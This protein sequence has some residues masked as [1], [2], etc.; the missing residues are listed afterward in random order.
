MVLWSALVGCYSGFDTEGGQLHLDPS[1]VS[2][3]G[4]LIPNETPL[5]EGTEVCAAISCSSSDATCPGEIHIASCFDQ[6]A[7]GGS[8]SG[9][10]CVTADS[11]GTLVW[12]FDPIADVAACSADPSTYTPEPDSVSFEVLAAAD[13]T[14]ILDQYAERYAE[15]SL[16]PAAGAFPEDWTVPHGEPFRVVDGGVL[17]LPI[18]FERD[19]D[20]TFV[21]VNETS[22]EVEVVTLEGEEPDVTVLDPLWIAV[23]PVPGGTSEVQITNGTD[24]WVAG[25]VV[26]VPADVASIEVV[27]ALGNDGDGTPSPAAARA[28]LRDSSGTLLYG[29]PVEW[30]LT[31]GDILVALDDVLPGP[32]YVALGDVCV[33]PRKFVPETRTATLEASFA[34]VRSSATFEWVAAPSTDGF[35]PDTACANEPTSSVEDGCTCNQGGA[36]W[37]G[38]AAFVSALARR[39]ASAVIAQ[40]DGS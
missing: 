12:H 23:T 35:V 13:V 40:V 25:T 26:G 36:P 15:A 9:D 38:L 1:G 16:V 22:F 30:A 11:A 19:S 3:D 20:G 4:G 31:D 6:S 39:R 24:E 10:N 18:M 28:V 32:D 34:G 2:V 37:L 27:V 8:I 7:E 29:A 21:A 33:A 17:Q 5:L 14:A